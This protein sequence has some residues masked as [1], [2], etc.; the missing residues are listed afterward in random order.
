[1]F[2]QVAFSIIQSLAFG[3]DAIGKTLT[4]FIIF[5]LV[6]RLVTLGFA[7]LDKTFDFFSI[8]PFLKTINRL[9]GAVFGL[10]EGGIV[11]GLILYLVQSF[12]VLNQVIERF[13]AGSRIV[14]YLI[15]FV[16]ILRPL[17][18]QVLDQLKQLI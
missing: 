12:A 5:T 7:M 9:A 2:Y 3:F 11:L 13:S 8:I 17:M 18:P 15:Q 6:N 14:P 1:M 10:I 4:F 16:E